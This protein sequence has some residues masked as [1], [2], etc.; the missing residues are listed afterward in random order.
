MCKSGHSQHYH[1]CTYVSVTISPANV[2][3]AGLRMDCIPFA[4]SRAGMDVVI[5]NPD[6]S[7]NLLMLAQCRSCPTGRIETRA[8]VKKDSAG[9]NPHLLC[10]V[11]GLPDCLLGRRVGRFVTTPSSCWVSG[12]LA[13]VG[14]AGHAQPAYLGQRV[15][16]A[17]ADSAAILH[18][19]DA[20]G[21]E[22]QAALR[23]YQDQRTAHAGFLQ[24]LAARH[25]RLMLAGQF[26]DWWWRLR[27]CIER[28]GERLFNH[29]S[30]Y[31]RIVF[32]QET[33]R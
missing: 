2:R 12:R 16:A 10:Q 8:E 17:L 19:L 29:R 24:R 1:D 13:L 14:D 11:A 9:R 23:S 31:Q 18:A 5:P 30:L 7:L 4:P 21:E 6:G 15:T 20:H 27:D 25:G 26:G 3:H 33:W 28:L 22:I 32:D